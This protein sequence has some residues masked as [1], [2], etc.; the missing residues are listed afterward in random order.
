[1]LASAGCLHGIY[2][3][4]VYTSI[5][6]DYYSGA[7]KSFFFWPFIFLIEKGKLCDAIFYFFHVELPSYDSLLMRWVNNDHQKSIEFSAFDSYQFPHYFILVWWPTS[8]LG[9]FFINSIRFVNQFS[10]MQTK[11]HMHP[12]LTIM[13]FFV[14]FSVVNFY[15]SFLMHS[16][17]TLMAERPARL[18]NGLTRNQISRMEEQPP[19][20]QEAENDELIS[21]VGSTFPYQIDSHKWIDVLSGEQYGQS[22]ASCT[23]A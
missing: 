20:Y 5:W 21:I 16:L 3:V 2:E 13:Y 1:M 8:E 22:F 19:K 4:S 15:V 7:F 6:T 23:V 17:M 11:I 9:D 10:G 12:W 14:L 18:Y